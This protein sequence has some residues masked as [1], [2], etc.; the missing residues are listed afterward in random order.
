MIRVTYI[1]QASEPLSADGLLALLNQCHRNNTAR[2]LTGML[3]FGNGTFLQSIEGEA[4]VVD[5]LIELISKDSR[6]RDIRILR[7]DKITERQYSEWSMGFERVTESTLE[8]IPSLRNFGLRN[9]NPDY[10][11]TH[12]DVVDTLLERHRAPHWDPLIR[13]LDARDKLIK[14]LRTELASARNDAEMAALVLETVV[15]VAKEGRID[16]A[17]LEICRSTLR[18]LR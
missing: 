8:A 15:E 3:L 5:P 2:G 17:H 7:R 13:E 12:G 10:L 11:S 18:S 6:H 16:D 4:V 1:S 14:E 9:F